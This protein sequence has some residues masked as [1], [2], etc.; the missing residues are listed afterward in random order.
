[1]EGLYCFIC[2]KK[3]P[4]TEIFHFSGILNGKKN[5]HI[6]ACT[7]CIEKYQLPIDINFDEIKKEEKNDRGRVKVYS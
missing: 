4:Y 1:M 6:H 2:N 5:G 7:C 3:Y